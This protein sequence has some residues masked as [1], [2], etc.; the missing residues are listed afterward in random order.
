MA[1]VIE[2]LRLHD[3][4]KLGPVRR[5]CSVVIRCAVPESSLM[6]T[7]RPGIGVMVREPDVRPWPD[8]TA[9]PQLHGDLKLDGKAGWRAVKVVCAVGRNSIS[10]RALA[11]DAKGAGDAA[12][13]AWSIASTIALPVDCTPGL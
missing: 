3:T 7:H 1:V 13:L 8:K 4:M 12:R 6:S 11:E 2:R 9:S 5:Y 10:Q